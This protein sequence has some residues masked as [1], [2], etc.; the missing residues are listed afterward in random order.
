MHLKIFVQYKHF[1]CC[2][3]LKEFQCV[4]AIFYSERAKL[5]PFCLSKYHSGG[6]SLWAEFRVSHEECTHTSAIV[7]SV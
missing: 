4:L 1:K 3:L 2:I 7:N 6:I 5:C